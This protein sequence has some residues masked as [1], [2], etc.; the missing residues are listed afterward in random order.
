MIASALDTNCI[1][2]INLVTAIEKLWI[3]IR[4]LV[5]HFPIADD[6]AHFHNQHHHYW[7]YL[8]HHPMHQINHH[9]ILL[10]L[11]YAIVMV[12][13]HSANATRYPIPA[14]T[15]TT[16][17][18]SM[19]IHSTPLSNHIHHPHHINLQNHCH[20]DSIQ[21]TLILLILLITQAVTA[22]HINQ[23]ISSSLTTANL[24]VDSS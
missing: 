6:H 19:S 3:S 15:T 24:L 10:L 8:Y 13:K 12:N 17:I 2:P 1:I 23:T 11:A 5:T 7:R 16:A 18:H 20:F 21:S 9:I 14:I 4:L 22:I